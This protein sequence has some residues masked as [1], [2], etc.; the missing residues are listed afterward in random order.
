MKNEQNARSMVVFNE[1]C[2]DGV[3]R[4]VAMH[5]PLVTGIKS[6]SK[7]G[8]IGQANTVIS[9]QETAVVDGTLV[10]KAHE[11]AVYEFFCDVVAAI[12]SSVLA[13][14][15]HRLNFIYAGKYFAER[16]LKYAVEPQ[17]PSP[18]DDPPVESILPRAPLIIP[19]ICQLSVCVST[20][21]S[22]ALQ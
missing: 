1:L 6:I 4:P 20:D 8:A 17:Q 7:L 16:G 22:I 12:G 11:V 3:F 14:D 15:Y 13:C 2:D 21:F 18:C 10:E 9:Y 19:S 5:A